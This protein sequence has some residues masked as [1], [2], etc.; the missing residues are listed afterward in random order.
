MCN[1]NKMN[2]YIEKANTILDVCAESGSNTILYSKLNENANI[3]SFEPKHSL[4]LQLS[5]NI[6]QNDI[7]NVTIFNNAIGNLSKQIH[8]DSDSD[9]TLFG[10]VGE[11]V[12]MITVDSLGL[13]NCDF[14]NINSAEESAKLALIGAIKTIRKY[15]PTICFKSMKPSIC[16]DIIRKLGDY[17]FTKIDDHRYLAAHVENEDTI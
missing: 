1:I 6:Q 11:D 13:T 9:D 10:L 12:D 4:F 3:Y 14:I 15:K 8:I 17:E 2:A 7:K 16:H 5:K